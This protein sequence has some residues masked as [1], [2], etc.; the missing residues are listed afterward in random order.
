[1]N[2]TTRPAPRSIDDPGWPLRLALVDIAWGTTLT[3]AAASA[4]TSP[5]FDATRCASAQTPTHKARI[6]KSSIAHVCK[7]V[8]A[9][10]HTNYLVDCRWVS[11]FAVRHAMCKTTLPEAAVF[12]IGQNT[13]RSTARGKRPRRHLQLDPRPGGGAPEPERHA[14]AG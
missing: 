1:V 7:G 9:A 11:I 3:A 10:L 13:S 4:V 5:G 14:A 6:I 2:D 12:L 8:L